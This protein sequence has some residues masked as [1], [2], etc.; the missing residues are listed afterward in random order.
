MIDY[1]KDCDSDIIISTRDIF[2]EWLGEY[3]HS[4]LKI[5]WEHNH[6]H[7]NMKYANRII[8]SVKN[9][10]YF[11]LVSKDLNS[12]YS[13]RVKCKCFFIPNSI[14][15]IPNVYSKLNNKRLI[16]VGRLSPEKGYLDLLNIFLKLHS[17]DSDYSLDIVGDGVLMNELEKFIS[18]NNL[19]NC[20][21]LHGFQST[22]YINKLLLNS[23]IYLMCSHTESFGI[24]LLEAMSYGLPC[25][26]FDSAEGAREVIEDGKN[27]YLISDRSF[28]NMIEKIGYLVDNSNVREKMGEYARKS[29]EKYTSDSVIKQ[30]YKIIEESDIDE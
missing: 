24:V 4:K 23:S 1:L 3:G 6:H 10:D 8:N 28:D 21:K 7:G 14:N 9:L 30:W 12:F 5:G 13:E 25:I 2:N 22:E 11:I 16:S 18:D 29:V 17:I 19:N 26:A 15:D 27:G 20:I